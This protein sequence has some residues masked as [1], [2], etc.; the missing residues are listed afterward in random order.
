MSTEDDRKMICF[1]RLISY[2]IMF[3]PIKLA[4][5]DAAL[6]V[7]FDDMLTD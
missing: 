7:Q 6:E 1:T 5:P 2:N 4:I 3:S